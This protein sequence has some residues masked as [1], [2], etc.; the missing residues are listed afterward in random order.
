MVVVM[1]SPWYVGDSTELRVW[2]QDMIGCPPLP[3]SLGPFSAT[4][5]V[6]ALLSLDNRWTNGFCH[7]TLSVS[8][9]LSC[10]HCR[11][12]THQI[13]AEHNQLSDFLR[14]LNFELAANTKLTVWLLC[15]LL[16]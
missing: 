6:T 2:K 8:A 11:T 4:K 13:K 1:V 3:F 7:L 16:I 10:I 14:F 12:E 9:L 5:L 15:H